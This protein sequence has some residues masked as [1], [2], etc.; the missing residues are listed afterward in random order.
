MQQTLR[1]S[2]SIQS[3]WQR[4]SPIAVAYLLLGFVKSIGHLSIYLIPGGLM[5]HRYVSEHFFAFSIA[6]VVFILFGCCRCLA[7]YWFYQYRINEGIIE[8]RS[9]VFEKR[10]LNLPF[11]RI[12]NVVVQQPFIYRLT[13]NVSVTLDSAGSKDD[14]VE[15][16]ALTQ[17]DA[18][19]LRES[20]LLTRKSATTRLVKGSSD[21]EAEKEESGLGQN[22]KLL[23][24]RK[25]KDLVIH[26]IAN[27]R[28]W[29]I[30]SFL[31]P[32]HESL[33]SLTERFLKSQGVNVD[34]VIAQTTATWWT[35]G[36]TFI[37]LMLLLLIPFSIL[38]VLGS[39]VV[40]YNYRLSRI[41]DRYI[42]RCGFFTRQEISLKLSRIQMIES[43]QD[44][45]DR[46]IGR[47]NLV[48]RQNVTGAE[49]ASASVVGSLLVPS[50]SIK[51]R[52]DIMTATWPDLLMHQIQYRSAS[53]YYFIHNTVAYILPLLSILSS[54]LWLVFDWRYVSAALILAVMATLL[55]FCY[56]RNL[57]FAA[58]ENYIYV[59]SGVIG[60]NYRCFPIYKLQQVTVKQ[61]LLMERRGLASVTFVLASG[62]INAPYL[63]ESDAYL[64]ANEAIRKTEQLKR[65]W[66]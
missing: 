63:D 21:N 58:D 2:L 14:E 1:P 57:G 41:E 60:L 9:G 42:R 32:M 66:M 24:V 47:V 12:Q 38:S 59:R 52:D 7:S 16:Y 49:R 8:V 35:T 17:Q 55:C 29:I 44:W 30:L 23:N 48:F 31:F 64:S 15:I 6:G 53:I 26:G 3:D 54:V 51:E 4:S 36:A 61:S 34:A 20:I 25:V 37:V 40:F 11:E 18:D 65:S 56:W 45:L 43:K 33:L 5:G 62:A 19:A 13:D 28:I 27:N 10:Y 22:E 50:I 46:L 39:L